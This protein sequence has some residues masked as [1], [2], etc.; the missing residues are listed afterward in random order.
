MGRNKKKTE[1]TNIQNDFDIKFKDS[2]SVLFSNLKNNKEVYVLI[3]TALGLVLS[4]FWNIA[5]GV[6]Y[7]GYADELSIGTLF[8]HK[9]NQDIL[10]SVVVFL[11][12]AVMCFPIAYAIYRLTKRV[13]RSI[14]AYIIA[15][16]SILLALNPLILYA[17]YL[18]IASTRV[19]IN[20]YIVIFVLVS[21]LAFAF[22]IIYLPIL[23]ALR[24]IDKKRNNEQEDE[25][26]GEQKTSSKVVSCAKAILAWVLAALCFLLSIYWFGRFGASVNS[27]YEFLVDDYDYTFTYDGDKVYDNLILSETDEIYYLTVCTISGSE[28]NSK[29]TIYPYYHTIVKKSD[30]ASKIVRKSFISSSIEKGNCPAFDNAP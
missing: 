25:Q 16:F 5:C 4:A 29:I 27:S 26:Q 6:W 18:L 13:Y 14:W 21:I 7:K 12:S 11:G 22:A 17:V 10:I 3:C 24:D 30:D 15:T 8:I 28:D 23:V 2:I 9:D 19:F 1:N 20:Q